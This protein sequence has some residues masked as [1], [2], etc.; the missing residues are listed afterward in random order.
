MTIAWIRW[1]LAPFSLI[2]CSL[3]EGRKILVLPRLIFYS[4]SKRTK[5][6]FQSGKGHCLIERMNYA[7][8][9]DID[10]FKST[11]FAHIRLFDIPQ[12][13]AHR[14]KFK[15]LDTSSK[16][17][18]LLTF[19]YSISHRVQLTDQSPKHGPLR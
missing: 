15:T 2:I 7:C 8:Q 11:S 19:D 10:N 14:S 3:F 4:M 5:Y 6:N 16:Q 9:T 1:L 18:R 12:S 13:T 17:R